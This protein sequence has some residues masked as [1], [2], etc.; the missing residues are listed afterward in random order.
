MTDYKLVPVEP[1][2]EMT[3][4]GAGCLPSVDGVFGL[5]GALSANV[6]RTMLSAAPEPVSDHYKLE[7]PLWA[8]HVIG[9]DD[10]YPAPDFE[11]AVQWCAEQ[12]AAFA[13]SSAETGVLAAFVP[14]LWPLSAEAH[15]EGLAA[16]VA[17]WT[18]PAQPLSNT[19]ELVAGIDAVRPETTSEHIARD[20]REGTFPK[21]SEPQMVP[22]TVAAPV[23][24]EPV[25]DKLDVAVKALEAADD[26][27][28]QVTAFEQDAREIMGNT[29]FEIC[30]KRRDEVRQALAQI[31]GGA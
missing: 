3:M 8:M 10:I 5:A 11:T 31:K 28:A 1:T 22:D 25:A 14:A 6:Y 19:Q 7:E 29:N 23:V 24:G 16:S 20:M 26:A 9:P 17:G 2:L 12:N 27:L 18:L 21:R 13:K 30:K 15:A 4:A